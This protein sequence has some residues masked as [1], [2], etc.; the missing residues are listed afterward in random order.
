MLYCAEL[1]DLKRWKVEETI[2]F[3]P[4]PDVLF[5]LSLHCRFF[6]LLVLPEL[7]C[8]GEEI[9]CDLPDEV[10]SLGR[11]EEFHDEINVLAVSH[12]LFERGDERGDGLYARSELRSPHD[13]L[14]LVTTL[15][16]AD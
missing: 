15:L 9:G 11:V 16:V 7:P 5:V 4:S 10:M 14:L 12:E 13:Y 2:V 3:L 6:G 8:L 1:D